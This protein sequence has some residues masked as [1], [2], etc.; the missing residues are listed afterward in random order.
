MKWCLNLLVAIMLLIVSCH[1][2]HRKI[3]AGIPLSEAA[4]LLK[5]AGYKEITDSVQIKSRNFASWWI[6]PENTCVTVVSSDDGSHVEAYLFAEKGKGYENML[7]WGPQT[8]VSVKEIQL[9]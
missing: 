2:Q 7:Q 5:E 1:A 4:A 6:S 9:R 3:V 8:K